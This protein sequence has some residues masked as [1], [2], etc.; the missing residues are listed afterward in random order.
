LGT[1][2]PN[3]DRVTAQMYTA[4]QWYPNSA[5][6][7]FEPQAKD[8]SEGSTVLRPKLSMAAY[9]RRRKVKINAR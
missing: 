2:I 7:A 5:S 3:A 4:A 6:E 1:T 9:L 8:E